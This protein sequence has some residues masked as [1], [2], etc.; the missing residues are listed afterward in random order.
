MDESLLEEVS[1]RLDADVEIDEDVRLLIDATLLDELDAVMEGGEARRPE[2]VPTVETPQERVYVA[3]LDIQGFRGIGPKAR[4]ELTPGPGLTLVVGRNGSG[5]SSFAEG[6][7]L[8][9]TGDNRRWSQRKSKEWRGGFRNVHAGGAVELA[10]EI[11]IEGPGPAVLEGRRG[12][13]RRH[14]HLPARRQVACLDRGARLGSAA[15]FLLA[16][17][18]AGH[19][20]R[21]VT[22]AADLSAGVPARRGAGAPG[23]ARLLGF[24]PGVPPPRLRADAGHVGAAA[25]DRR[26]DGFR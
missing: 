20:K 3:S 17:A 21:F 14:L 5:K 22:D 4:L 19:G 6:L 24:E 26:G 13:R 18:G 1:A 10:A 23:D 7:E 12:A 9:L 8:L 16:H 2:P 25:L 11:L 15:T